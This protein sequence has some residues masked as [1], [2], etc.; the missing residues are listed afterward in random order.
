MALFRRKR[1]D[2]EREDRCPVCSEPVP[3]GALECM[4]CGIDLRPLRHQQ[5]GADVKA[6]GTARK[7]PAIRPL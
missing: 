6:D 2:D 4:M 5:P 7:H 1:G 3:H